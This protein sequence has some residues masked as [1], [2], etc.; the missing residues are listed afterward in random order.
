VN[1]TD[2]SKSGEG[3]AENESRLPTA[4]AAAIRFPSMPTLPGLALIALCGFGRP[5]L[6]YSVL[7]EARRRVDDGVSPKMAR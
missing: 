2:F 1:R 5:V 7:V 3:A 6:N 4:I